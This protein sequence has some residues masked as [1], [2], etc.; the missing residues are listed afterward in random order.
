MIES[1]F[2][3]VSKKYDGKYNLSNFAVKETLGSKLPISIHSL[4]LTHKEIPINITYEFGN[5]NL[6]EVKFE[7]Y[8]QIKV[9][10]FELETKDHFSRL[11]SFK[12]DPWKIKP[13]NSQLSVNIIGYLNSTGLTKMANDESFEPIM[14]GIFNAGIYEFNTKF[15]LGFNNKENSITPIIEFHK[16][17]IDHFKERYCI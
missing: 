1:K 9:P 6:A 12:K 7:M 4:D 16:A 14:K 15:Y 3:E 10:D 13:L 5:S 8:V 17:L 11:F 2:I